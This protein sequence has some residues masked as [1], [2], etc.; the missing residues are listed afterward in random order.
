MTLLTLLII[1]P[2]IASI[3]IAI[4]PSFSNSLWLNR[5]IPSNLENYLPNFKKWYS[6]S[7]FNIITANIFQT[8]NKGSKSFD[9]SEG[10]IVKT[11]AQS[12]KLIALSASLLNLFISLILWFQFDGSSPSGQYQFVS[13][14]TPLSIFS[15][16]VE[17][18]LNLYHFNF[19]VDGI[20]LYFLLLTT[21]IT[22]IALLSNLN[23]IKVNLPNLNYTPDVLKRF[24]PML[25]VA[26]L[27]KLLKMKESITR[28]DMLPIK[29]LKEDAW[30]D[31]PGKKWPHIVAL[32]QKS[33]VVNDMAP[34]TC[35]SYLKGSLVR[36]DS[37]SGFQEHEFV[38]LSR[39]VKD[40]NSYGWHTGD[41]GVYIYHT[42][43]S[44]IKLFMRL[45]D[46]SPSGV[47]KLDSY[48]TFRF[49]YDASPCGFSSYEMYN[50]FGNS[51]KR[52][53]SPC[54]FHAHELYK[55]FPKLKGSLVVK[56]FNNPSLKQNLL[57][58]SSDNNYYNSYN[59]KYNSSNSMVKSPSGFNAGDLLNVFP[60]SILANPKLT[61]DL[62]LSQVEKDT[63]GL[64]NI[65]LLSKIN[66]IANMSDIKT[67]SE[68]DAGIVGIE[69]AI[70]S[71]PS[72]NPL[73][74]TLNFGPGLKIFLI[75][76]LLL[77]SLQICAFVSLDL[78]MFYI[79][80]ESILPIVFILIIIF[81]HGD[82]RI[83]SAILFFL[84]TLAGSLP[85]L[86]SILTI[87]SFVGST[88]FNIIALNEI[89]L[90]SQKV[91]WIGF[92]IA[93]AV[94]TPLMPFS[95]WL[96]KAHS[97]SPLAGSI[98][99]AGTMLK[100]ATYGYLRVLINFLPDATNYFSAFVQSIA[101]FTL[102]FASLATIVQQDSKKLVAYSSI[103]H[104]AVCVL[105]LFSNTVIGI[106]GA[107]LLS[108][109]H[110][111]VSPALFICVGGVIYDRAHTRAIPYIRGITNLM[112]IFS[113]YFFIFIIANTGIP[114]TLNFLGEQLALMGVFI[115]NPLT[116]AIGAVGIVLS[117][118]YSLYMYNRMSYGSYS[119]F[120]KPFKDINRR[121]F[122]LLLILL[123]PTIMLGIFPNIIMDTIHSDISHL[124]Y[125]VPT[126]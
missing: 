114:L 38:Y 101:I 73:R 109:A 28:V 14:Y 56:S 78:L 45:Y 123:I 18:N 77:E 53:N 116:A 37:P 72:T 107:I 43:N 4:T 46:E 22:P 58:M 39:L 12:L 75:S 2:I 95:I 26:W 86:L 34:Q 19:G 70:T 31:V 89:S 9:K 65:L 63:K 29:T 121:E 17:G 110:G 80:F 24:I 35:K 42:K 69:Q 97:D 40:M 36:N 41:N 85:M 60:F 55:V 23:N 113:A 50:L 106:E 119:I 47:T 20:S 44:K 15:S 126:I 71:V 115:R 21:F 67:A 6:H 74:L 102:V 61:S 117:A 30:T 57:G 11:S 99:L 7:S 79:F 96:P 54:G 94:K 92:F 81:G 10:Q 8:F 68:R 98:I 122:N 105:G 62:T 25:L 112:P 52:E 59:L 66:K 49:L 82:D 16:S 64:N 100:L 91:L 88:D 33:S 32:Y 124:V 84:F 76:I 103:A 118:V 83:R 13:E 87:Y 111:F 3:Y 125:K 48:L 104:M 120:V 27:F 90:E 93:F 5:T 51:V 108:I 1:I